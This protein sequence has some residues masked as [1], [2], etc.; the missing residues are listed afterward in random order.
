MELFINDYSLEDQYLHYEKDEDFDKALLQ[1]IGTLKAVAQQKQ[2]YKQL[3]IYAETTQLR[4]FIRSISQQKDQSPKTVFLRTLDRL[5][6]RNWRKEQVHTTECQYVSLDLQ[7][8]GI[9]D[10]RGQLWAEVAERTL[11]GR[12]CL[13]LNFP[14]SVFSVNR[15]ITIIKNEGQNPPVLVNLDWADNK[16][17][18]HIWVQINLEISTV[19]EDSQHLK[20]IHNAFLESKKLQEFD[21]SSWKPYFHE[22]N[23]KTQDLGTLFPFIE[24]SDLLVENSNWSLFEKELNTLKQEERIGKIEAMGRQ[25][26]LINGWE[27]SNQL[28]ERNNRKIYLPSIQSANFYLALDTQHG[29]FE[30]HDKN[31]VHL[32]SVMFNHFVKKPKSHRI[33]V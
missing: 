12:N 7:Q 32:G 20:A 4:D 33:S 13:L 18:V 25:I 15:Y 26:A 17:A 30:V 19:V 3:T 14:N 9:D 22:D 21:W 31:G 8:L 11:K 1:F 28:S 6:V 2:V 27:Y 29:E 23:Y 16:V 5:G 10:I 24:L